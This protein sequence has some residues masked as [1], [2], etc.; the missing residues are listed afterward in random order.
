MKKKIF[1]L[2]NFNQDINS[3]M[4]TFFYRMAKDCTIQYHLYPHKF[5][6][7]KRIVWIDF[8]GYVTSEFLGKKNQ[9]VQTLCKLLIS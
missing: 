4:H 5:P 2:G 8:K 9:T 6:Y 7:H 3:G 1:M